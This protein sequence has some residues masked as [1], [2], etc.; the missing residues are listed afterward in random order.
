MPFTDSIMSNTPL[1]FSEILTVTVT[2]TVTVT[3]MKWS[4]E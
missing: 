1:H 2:V 3:E 4:E